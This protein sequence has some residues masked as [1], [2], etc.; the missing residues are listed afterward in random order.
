MTGRAAISISPA[1]YN[2]P[3]KAY[4]ALEDLVAARDEWARRNVRHRLILG[5]LILLV[6][7]AA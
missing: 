4:V 2:R 3:R 6:L 5:L 7:C 1:G